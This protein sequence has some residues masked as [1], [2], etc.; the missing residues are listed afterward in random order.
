M[1]GSLATGTKPRPA[2][3][4]SGLAQEIQAALRSGSKEARAELLMRLVG[5]L[6]TGS[7]RLDIYQV[8]IFDDAIARLLGRVELPARVEVATR[9]AHFGNPLPATLNRL[10]RDDIAAARPVLAG[11]N[12]LSDGELGEVARIKGDGHLFALAAREHV[13][14]RV[15]EVIV[16]RGGVQVLR[17]LASNRGAKFSEAGLSRMVAKAAMDEELASVVGL[18]GDL[19]PHVLEQLLWET[20][21]EVRN[22]LV[23]GASP[24]LRQLI[25]QTLARIYRD[26]EISDADR[27][28]LQAIEQEMRTR[29]PPDEQAVVAFAVN[30]RI[31][32]LTAAISILSAARLDL[33]SRILLGPRTD[34]VLIACRSARLSWDAIEPILIHRRGDHAASRQ[35]IAA[36]RS[37]F[38]GL[39]LDTAQRTLQAMAAMPSS[40]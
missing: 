10:A 19:P 1:S 16:D 37:E 35:G 27:Q 13:C 11:K 14:D 5:R 21:D 18:R 9:L 25:E 32:D 34:L 30:R 38:E 31:L 2:A 6:V 23:A 8:A 17:R 15:T 22:R 4:K 3:P 29:Q 20:T 39:Q 36:A 40:S 7:P 12:A 26:L 33:I 28:R 24:E